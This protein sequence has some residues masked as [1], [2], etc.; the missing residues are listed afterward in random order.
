MKIII[1]IQHPAH[2]HFFKNIVDIL[3]KRNHKVHV[4]IKSAD[5]IT[6]LLTNYNIEYE[7]ITERKKSVTGLMQNQLKY[8]KGIIKR[9]LDIRPDILLAIGE[10]AVAH[11]STLF[12]CSSFLFLDSE[13][14]A[15]H[16]VITIPFAD[17][18]FTPELH[19]YDHGRKH[20]RYPGYHELAYLHP[21]R[22]SPNPD[23][24]RNYGIDPD[25]KYFVVRF[26]SWKAY[27]DVN[28]SGFSRK[29]K[30]EITSLLSEDGEVFVTT[31]D[32][33]PN[34]FKEYKQPIPPHLMHDLL[35]HANMYVGDSQTMA[36]EAAVLGTPAIR[37]NSFAGDGDMSN[38]QELE[39]DYQLLISKSD[40]REA[41]QTIQRLINDDD[42][43]QKWEL[44]RKNLLNDKIDVTPFVIDAIE[45][46]CE[47]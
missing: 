32:E 46:Q 22:F 6:N 27:H 26:I 29:A 31:E 37:S 3:K 34:E 13:P 21:N 40:E 45:K 1:T 16:K 12:D 7:K 18:I 17:K 38:F 9:A 24:L 33:L 43:E 28:Q 47:S 20:V 4:F 36:T 14:S 19:R 42:R 8:E 41:I 10:P 2:V 44:R 15:V 11:V 30:E 35:Y 39:R 23:A 5:I 25:E